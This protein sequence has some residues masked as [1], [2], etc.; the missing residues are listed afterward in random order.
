MYMHMSMHIC[1]HMGASEKMY[2][3]QR[4]TSGAILRNVVYIL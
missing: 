2:G 1:V 4:T 3:S